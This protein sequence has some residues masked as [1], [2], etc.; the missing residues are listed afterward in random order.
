MVNTGTTPSASS[1]AAQHFPFS[2]PAHF[3]LSFFHGGITQQESCSNW[4][5][6]FFGCF[7]E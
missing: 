3:D 5:M 1:P 4:K 6:I 2:S 7:F